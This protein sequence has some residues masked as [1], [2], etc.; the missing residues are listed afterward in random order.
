ME[1]GRVEYG[2]RYDL[3]SGRPR[4]QVSSQ[5]SRISESPTHDSNNIHGEVDA[6]PVPVLQIALLEPESEEPD[7][8]DAQRAVCS[9]N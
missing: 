1:E 2:H 9:N 8:P 7:I 5:V 3:R 6:T 4:E